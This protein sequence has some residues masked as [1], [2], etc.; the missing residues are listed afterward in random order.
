MSLLLLPLL[1]LL[2]L[3]L[4]AV[5]PSICLWIGFDGACA[6]AL[7]DV[8]PHADQQPLRLDTATSGRR[9]TLSCVRESGARSV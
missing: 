6:P 2:L 3:L 8:L 1:L 5:G 9:A 7:A 4:L